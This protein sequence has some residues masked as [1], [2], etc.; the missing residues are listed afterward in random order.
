[1]IPAYRNVHVRPQVRPFEALFGVL[2]ATAS[3]HACILTITVLN[4]QRQLVE[5]PCIAG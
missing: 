1:M 3:I 4:K 2:L 5:S